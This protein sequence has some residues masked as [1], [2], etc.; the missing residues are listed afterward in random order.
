MT[1]QEGDMLLQLMQGNADAAAFIADTFSV[2]HIW[3]D[4]IDRDKPLTDDDIDGAFWR[5]LIEL[6]RNAFYRQHFDRL[7]PIL[8]VAITDWKTA[9]RS[10][11]TATCLN[12]RAMSYTIRSSY[13]NLI[14]HAAIIIGG[15]RYGL[16]IAKPV[17]EYFHKEGL[18]TY[19]KNLRAERAARE[20][21][22]V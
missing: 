9:T 1:P 22:D 19:I 5:A 3:D 7:N 8:M 4:L 10:E 13:L 17:R 12:E 2:L 11:R 15:P 14:V 21:A 18:T 6:P 16:A 20:K